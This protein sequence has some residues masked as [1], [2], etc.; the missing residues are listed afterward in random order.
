MRSRARCGPS[1]L[2]MWTACAPASNSLCGRLPQHSPPSSALDSPCGPS[3]ATTSRANA[4]LQAGHSPHRSRVAHPPGSF[5]ARTSL[6][7]K[8]C[9]PFSSRNKEVVM[10]KIEAI[11]KPFKLDEVK[12]ALSA[13]GIQ[14]MTISEV[15]GFGRQRGH[16]E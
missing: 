12:E 14:G 16:T 10:K 15:K 13:E 7:G 8:Y 5:L 4:S 11:I 6:P 3:F 2:T 1:S 9:T